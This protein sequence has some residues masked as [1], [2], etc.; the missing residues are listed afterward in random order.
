MSNDLNKKLKSK[1]VETFCFYWNRCFYSTY[2]RTFN[3]QYYLLKK[4]EITICIKRKKQNKQIRFYYFNWKRIRKNKREKK[5][6][7]TKN[8]CWCTQ[9]NANIGQWLRQIIRN[10]KPMEKV[11]RLFMQWSIF[12]RSSFFAKRTATYWK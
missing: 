10:L 9:T 2:I 4:T 8:H 12:R 11:N 1:S 7:E 5:S 6:E 3:F